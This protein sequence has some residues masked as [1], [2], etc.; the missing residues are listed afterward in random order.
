[1]ETLNKAFQHFYMNIFKSAQREHFY[2]ETYKSAT[3]YF[4]KVRKAVSK[5]LKESIVEITIQKIRVWRAF[6]FDHSSTQKDSRSLDPTMLFFFFVTF[7]ALNSTLS[8][9]P[10]NK[11]KLRLLKFSFIIFQRS[12]L[13]KGY[14]KYNILYVP[15]VLKLC[16]RNV[17]APKTV[18]LII[19]LNVVLTSGW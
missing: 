12:F 3:T 2:I 10:F 8:S 14:C 7:H 5:L 4:Q 19:S 16:L 15:T 17:P 18:L 6:H 1:M 11:M 9:F 13:Q